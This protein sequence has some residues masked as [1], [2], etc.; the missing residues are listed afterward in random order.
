MPH[1]TTGETPVKHLFSREIRTKLPDIQPTST[2]IEDVCDCDYQHKMKGKVHSDAKRQA[3]QSNINKGDFIIFKQDRENKLSKTFSTNQYKVIEKKGNELTAQVE[4]GEV[5]RRI[6]T[7]VKPEIPANKSDLHNMDIETNTP[8]P[9][10]PQKNGPVE[11]SQRQ[12][13]LPEK[14]KD[15]VMT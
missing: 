9:P 14:F 4:E 3:K 6:T 12:I 7:L 8:T 11:L 5:Y 1:C 13:K 15:F 10:S 2:N